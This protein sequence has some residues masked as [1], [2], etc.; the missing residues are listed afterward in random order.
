MER[1]RQQHLVRQKMCKNLLHFYKINNHFYER[2]KYDQRLLKNM[3]PTNNPEKM[4][5][6][7]NELE[8][9]SD[10]IDLIDIQQQR[11]NYRLTSINVSSQWETTII[12]KLVIFVDTQVDN[13]VMASKVA[14][15]PLFT[16]QSS[17][18]FVKYNESALMFPHL[19][20]YGRG[21][22]NERKRRIK[23]SAFECAKHYIM[24]SSRRFAQDKYYTLA[25]FD[26]LSMANAY[27]RIN[28]RAKYNPKVYKNYDT[29]EIP[30]LDTALK[31]REMRRRGI[32]N[33]S[34][35]ISENNNT[36]ESKRA[37]ALLK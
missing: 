26:R 18:I 3:P 10:V 27:T 29:V 23:M 33:D 1:I 36:E 30:A 28:V 37:D 13:S 35:T 24:L 11:I 12:E 9:S 19:F 6:R 17:N 7:I 14:K 31:K 15:E 4:F 32:Y 25:I 16:V 20:P 2:V 34:S 21:H 22:P 5:D 8:I